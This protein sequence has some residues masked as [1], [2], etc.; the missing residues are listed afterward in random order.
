MRNGDWKSSRASSDWG[1]KSKVKGMPEFAAVDRPGVVA[2]AIR[3]YWALAV[4]ALGVLIWFAN[5]N[6]R[7]LTEPDEGRY[8]EIPREMLVSGDWITPHL[9]G[10]LYLEK[11]PLQYW[12]TALAYSALG[13]EPW[14]SRLWGTTLG[15]LGIVVTYLLGRT[16]WDRRTGLLAALI[17]A[18]CPLYFIVG[19]INTLD[20]GLAFFLNAALAC[21]I[22][23]QRAPVDSSAQRHWLWLCW[24]LL[25]LGFLQKGLVALVLPGLALGVYSLVYRDRS[26]WRRMHLGAGVL[27]VTVL[28]A[29]WLVLVSARNPDFL[30][31]F[32]LHEHLERFTTTVHRRVEPWWY[33]IAILLVGVI[34]WL[35]PMAR[36]AFERLRSSESVFGERLLLV[37]A[38]T[39]VVFFSLSGSKLAPYI[40]PAVMP[41]AL[42]SGRWLTTRH[43]SKPTFAIAIPMVVFCLLLA[44]SGWLVPRLI[45]PG[46][47]RTAYLQ[48]SAWAE[49]AAAITAI[50]IVAHVFLLKRSLYQA[51]AA[52]AVA[53]TTAL[54]VLLCASNSIEQVRG[55]KDLDTFLAPYLKRDTPFYCVGMYWQT[56]TFSLRRTCTTVAYEGELG[57]RFDPQ[58]RHWI[59]RH[60]DFVSRWNSLPEGVAV[61]NPP[62]WEILQQYGVQARIVLRDSN[63]I[64]MVKP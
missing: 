31:F 16:L 17:L 64:V 39:V 12:A 10:L 27:I 1:S 28:V 3:R 30:H 44:N 42:V 48:I 9:N 52:L 33:F 55:R 57:T 29:P 26:F 46:I 50:G 4:F 15:M 19:H 11:P 58:Q 25:G 63:V 35:V 5:I 59:Q 40:T 7:T 61:V 8:A 22:V 13:Q 36:A 24:C 23:G 21:F 38:L 45:E 60:E 51:S 62:G 18:S 47:K 56:L 43:A 54:A 53:F 2:P 14:V 20:I 6:Y 34:P 32:F 41:L 49:A 37:W